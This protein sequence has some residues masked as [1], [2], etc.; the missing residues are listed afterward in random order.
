MQLTN[1][2]RFL[3]RVD[4]L[5]FMPMSKFLPGFPSL[6]AETPQSIWFTGDPDTD[7]W[8]WKDRAAEDKHVAFGCL[9]NGHRGFV[10]AS[11]Y[12][13][14]FKAFHPREHMEERRAY[15]LVNPT[16]WE[17]WRLFEMQPRLSTSEIR[18]L[19][20]VMHKSGGS[21]VDGAVK[22]LQRLYY[23]TVAG[24][25]RKTDRFGR[26]YAWPANLYEKVVDWA[27]SGWLKPIPGMTVEDAQD[28]ILD[29]GIEIGVN[30]SREDLAKK[31]GFKLV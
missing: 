5:G 28:E 18:R 31:L 14:F 16:V 4:E 8:S 21:K 10:S 15:G 23:I 20:G 25:R 13:F 17:L 22:E 3:A 26:P 29:R 19:M 27:P 30:V 24:N 12:P 1:Y 11:M 6:S 2:S 7:P 9:L